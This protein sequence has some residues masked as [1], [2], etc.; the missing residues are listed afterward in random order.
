[1]I[2]APGLMSLLP[3]AV[4]NYLN[5]AN[6]WQTKVEVDQAFSL[7][8]ASCGACHRARASLVRLDDGGLPA[9]S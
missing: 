1:L 9:A 7:S 8:V 2:G 3:S 5:A 4:G 6:Q